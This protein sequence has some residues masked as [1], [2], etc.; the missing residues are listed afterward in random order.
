VLW[1]VTLLLCPD[2]FIHVLQAY[3]TLDGRKFSDAE[4]TIKYYYRCIRVLAAWKKD[5]RDS[6]DAMLQDLQ[7]SSGFPTDDEEDIFD[8]DDQAFINA[9]VKG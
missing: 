8:D 6:F 2:K 9:L 1:S 3:H 7:A 5:D 4:E